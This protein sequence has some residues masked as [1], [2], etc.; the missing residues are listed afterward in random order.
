VQPLAF[1]FTAA[2]AA[3]GVSV[4]QQPVLFW[5]VCSRADCPAIGVS[6]LKQ[7]ML[8]LDV[9]VLQQPLS[10]LACLFYKQPLLPL[11]CLFA[12]A[13]VAQMSSILDSFDIYCM[14]TFPSVF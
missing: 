3:F 10:P 13:C 7:P 14:K 5:R 4:L 12:A 6:V 9:S 8:L 1:L 11:A 2:Y